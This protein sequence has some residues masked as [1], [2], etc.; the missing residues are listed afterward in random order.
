LPRFFG[1]VDGLGL[2]SLVDDEDAGDEDYFSATAELAATATDFVSLDNGATTPGTPVEDGT[3]DIFS[4]NGT[5]VGIAVAGGL[6]PGIAVAVA[7]AAA[8]LPPI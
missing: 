4:L 7:A 6:A 2:S 8:T 3:G 1:F 5:D